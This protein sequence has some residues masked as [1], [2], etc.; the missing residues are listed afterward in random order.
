M[1]RVL[2]F[3]G[4]ALLLGGALFLWGGCA[5]T[6]PAGEA[7]AEAGS[8]FG[9]HVISGVPFLPQEEDTCGPSSL[10][11]LLRFHGKDATTGELIEETRTVGL[12]GTLITDLAAAGADDAL[13][14]LIGIAILVILVIVIIKLMN[15][16]VV[17]R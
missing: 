14:I 10:A 12:R 7:P 8:G 13:G 15:K 4:A 9:T 6:R 2:R 11:M 3:A 5:A 16:E 17:I 1:P